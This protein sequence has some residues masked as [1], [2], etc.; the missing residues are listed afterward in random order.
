M[1][2]EDDRDPL[3]KS[4]MKQ[5]DVEIT[6]LKKKI[7]DLKKELDGAWY[8]IRAMERERE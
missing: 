4:Q 3:M 1:C 8:T 2:W 5:K 7:E 6:N